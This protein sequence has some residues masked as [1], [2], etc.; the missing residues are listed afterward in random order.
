MTDKKE[1]DPAIDHYRAHEIKEHAEQ[2]Y[3]M[4]RLLAMRWGIK[5]VNERNNPFNY[6]T[7]RVA[8]KAWQHAYLKLLFD[9]HR[10]R[11]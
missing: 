10:G 4:D 8:Y 5:A 9:K 3:K 11:E 2:T 7:H 6:H 1:P